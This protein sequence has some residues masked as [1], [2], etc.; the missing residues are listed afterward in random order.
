MRKYIVMFALWL[1]LLPA[2]VAVVAID[3]CSA[4]A[5]DKTAPPPAT[6]PVPEVDSLRWQN[7]VLRAAALRAQA[8]AAEAAANALAEQLQAKAP[9]GY[10]LAPAKNG[11]LEYALKA[12]PT[13]IATPT[14]AKP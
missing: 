7:H 10:T 2:L 5:D 4:R 3:A 6:M 11:G 8:E 13:P 12:A 14:A 1:L 9:A